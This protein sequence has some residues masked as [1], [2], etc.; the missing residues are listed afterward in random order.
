MIMS[1]DGINH[2]KFVSLL[3]GLRPHALYEARSVCEW[4]NECGIQ[5]SINTTGEIAVFDELIVAVEGEWGRGISPFSL[6]AAAIRFF[7]F[8]GSI[9]SE[10]TGRGFIYD[11]CLGQLERSLRERRLLDSDGAG[12]RQAS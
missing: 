10:M 12:P 4:L 11:D 9:R 6:L 3:T 8:G 7:G 2:S 5:C 1:A